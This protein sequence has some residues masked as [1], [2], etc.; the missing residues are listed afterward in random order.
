VENKEKHYIEESNSPWS[1][2]WFFIK[3]KD[4]SLR[5]IQDYREVNKWTICDVYPMPQIEQIMEE[6]V[7]KKLFTKFN[8][9]FRYHDIQI[10]EE[11]YWKATFKTP[12]GLYHPNIMLFSLCNS[13]ATFQRLTNQIL[14][15]VQAKYPGVVHRYID[16]YLI[17][18]HNDPKFHEEVVGAVLK[19]MINEDLYLKLA[20]CEFSKPAIE[21]LGIYIKDGTICIDPTKQ[22]GLATWPRQLSSVMQV[23]STLGVIGYQQP[24]I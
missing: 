20:K 19:Q 6:L 16:D 21:Y 10:K 23:R 24:F 22:S 1:T 12:F 2:P 13:P 15:P 11:D 4:G 3:K 9:Y 7:D 14:V 18:T 8:I 17:T 5:P